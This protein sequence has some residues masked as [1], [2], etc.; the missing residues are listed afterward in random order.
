MPRFL[1]HPGFPKTGTKSLQRNLF[2]RHDS[3]RSLSARVPSQ[4]GIDQADTTKAFY[5][6][7]YRSGPL[8]DA[9][10]N[11]A[12]LPN[13][14]AA[15][16]NIVSEEAFL[17]NYLPFWEIAEFLKATI[18]P[19][20]V[21]ITVREQ[22]QVFR[23]MYDMT[24]DGSSSFSD[25]TAQQLRDSATTFAGALFY[26]SVAAKYRQLYGRESVLILTTDQL[27]SGAVGAT[28]LAE[29]LDVDP[30]DIDSLLALPRVNDAS[31][32][33]FNRLRLG[34][35]L[36]PLVKH[37]PSPVR[38]FGRKSVQ[39]TMR[40]RRTQLDQDTTASIRDFYAGQSIADAL[41]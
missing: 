24:T 39:S 20:K 5:R 4:D 6:Q 31:R 9:L 37:L 41:R 14:S 13:A 33:A 10:W 22:E 11:S 8:D 27:Y 1:I 30:R 40:D 26:Q 32:H 29:F 21:L 28:L 12:L 7:F 19:A 23:S 25:W 35:M 15:A 36:R 18:G 16:W 38:R 2:A 17:L 3:F 34:R